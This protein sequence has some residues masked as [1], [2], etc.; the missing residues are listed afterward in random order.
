MKFVNVMLT[1]TLV[2]VCI[3]G[4]A[5][6]TFAVNLK[7]YETF[8]HT[9]IVSSSFVKRSA[10]T[11]RTSLFQELKFSI[12]KRDFQL[13]LKSG[14][15]VL[16]AGFVGQLVHEDGKTSP[17]HVNQDLIFKGHL[18]DNPDVS[19]H[20]HKEDYLWSIQIFEKD[21]IYAVEPARNLLSPAENPKNHSLVAYKSTDLPADGWRCG[22]VD[23]KLDNMTKANNTAKSGVIRKKREAADTCVIFVIGSYKLF[24]DRCH[25]NFQS[26]Y[27]LL[28]SYVHLTDKVFRSS[29]FVGYNNDIISNIGLQ[30][31][32][33]LLYTTPS[34]TSKEH[35][36]PHYNAAGIKWNPDLKMSSFAYHLASQK[37]FFCH[38]HLFTQYPLPNRVLGFAYL[39]GI[40]KN[41]ASNFYSIGITSGEDTN[42]GLV[43]SLQM[44]LV[45]AHGHNFGSN[46]DPASDECSKPDEEGGNFLMWARSVTGLNPNHLLFSPCS[47]KQIGQLVEVANCLKPRSSITSFCGNGVRDVGE[48]CDG[49][50]NSIV[51]LDQCCR[52]D[53]TLN[54]TAT[55]SDFNTVCCSKCNIADANT[56]CEGSFVNE[57]KKA[58]YCTGL[59]Y[60]CAPAEFLPDNSS[61]LDGGKCYHG[62]CKSFCA[63]ESIEL[64]KT[65]E[66]CLCRNREDECKWCC[67]DNSDPERPGTC[68]PYSKKY[69]KDG[70]PC[71][72]GFCEQGRCIPVV[73]TTIKR[74][75]SF[76]VAEEK[77]RIVSIVR[78]NIVI[79]VIVVI[80]LVWIP[81]S[82]FI[83][84]KD[85]REARRRDIIDNI[86][87]EQLRRRMTMAT[88]ALDEPGSVEDINDDTEQDEASIESEDSKFISIIEGQSPSNTT[89]DKTFSSVIDSKPKSPVTEQ[90]SSATENKTDSSAIDGA[91]TI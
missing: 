30:I 49:G 54:L 67:Y 69:K 86:Y 9:D 34:T 33:I 6:Y 80:L 84:R 2:T 65:L 81:G 50:T 5:K 3:L 10:E 38:H 42:A 11:S 60:T 53:C 48:E 36:L 4:V 75:Y 71:N 28:I 85:K 17:F 12:L 40:C 91:A 31:G 66:P 39:S 59:S 23:A 21:E 16:A 32:K 22:V 73:T 37:D 89:S 46:H 1:A 63:M 56:I 27:S 79:T 77:V 52:P 55:C 25:Y 62:E 72:A 8:S 74:I 90:F 43:S 76:L 51:G 18:K 57:C 26:C 7:Y 68:K 70:S 19:V 14:T 15:D 35:K 83:Y 13:V 82:C 78:S 61:C 58:R 88:N 47:L 45:F 29:S 44:N 20:A 64:S 41:T 24:R 87:A